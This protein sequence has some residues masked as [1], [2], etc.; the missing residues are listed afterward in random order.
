MVF[1][2]KIN[3]L[4]Y[5]RHKI[6]LVI[7]TISCSI[8]FLN[9]NTAQ[10]GE[11]MANSSPIKNL[12]SDILTARLMEN[13]PPEYNTT[14]GGYFA[15]LANPTIGS[16]MPNI[17]KRAAAML[18]TLQK[19]ATENITEASDELVKSLQESKFLIKT[20]IIK[21]RDKASSFEQT[22]DPIRGRKDTDDMLNRLASGEVLHNPL[23]KFIADIALND[24]LPGISQPTLNDFE[25]KAGGLEQIITKFAKLLE[26]VNELP[27]A[28]KSASGGTAIG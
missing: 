26:K 2:I 11:A 4:S 15:D 14:F 23:D 1:A 3:C 20:E 16:T 17:R 8:I 13:T 22:I 28:S 6:K 19:L 18:E 12:A 7:N 24:G 27:R 10:Q 25:Q 21:L 5:L 9:V